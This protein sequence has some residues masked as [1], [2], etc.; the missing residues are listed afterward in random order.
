[1][2]VELV[3]PVIGFFNVASLGL[4]L[5]RSFGSL[6]GVHWSLALSALV[7]LAVASALL[8]LS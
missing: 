1:V 3:R 7:M 6:I 2:E 8:A 5:Q 4:R